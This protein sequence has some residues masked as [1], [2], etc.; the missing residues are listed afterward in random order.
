MAKTPDSAVES[1]SQ[2]LL[3]GSQSTKAAI[4]KCNEIRG[5]C[6]GSSLAVVS[7]TE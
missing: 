5:G 3:G 4:R 6:P 1:Q 7:A 2:V